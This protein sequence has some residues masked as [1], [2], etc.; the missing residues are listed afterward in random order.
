[1]AYNFQMMLTTVH[2]Q[3]M[4]EALGDIFSPAGLK[5][6]I[7]AN[8]GQ[9]GLRGQFGHDEYHFDNNAFDQ[10]YAYIAE[11]RQ[12]TLDALQR[13]DIPTALAAFGRL[14]H[15]AQDFYA[16][17]NYVDLWLASRSSAPEIDPVDPGMISHPGLHSGKLYYPQEAL[18]FFRPLREFALSILPR[19]SHAHMNL[20][21]AECGPRFEYAFRAAVSRTRL[22]FEQVKA[23]LSAAELAAFTGRP[24]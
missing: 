16:H 11:Q 20:D 22:E 14:T 10:G 15:T 2:A 9:D 4:H 7:A 21:S 24:S 3:I 8:L 17:T 5:A 19:D 13:R 18:Y 6:L 12:L 23:S 1:M